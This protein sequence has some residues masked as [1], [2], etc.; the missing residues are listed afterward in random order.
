[1]GN[2][3]C[4]AGRAVALDPAGRGGRGAFVPLAAR[5]RPGQ[6]PAAPLTGTH[7]AR[8]NPFWFISCTGSS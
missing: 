6:R 3:P 2:E 1:M 4:R 7:R 5:P 8:L